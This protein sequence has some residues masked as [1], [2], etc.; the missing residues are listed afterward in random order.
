MATKMDRQEDEKIMNK[1]S[2][3]TNEIETNALFLAIQVETRIRSAINL[4]DMK[5]Y[6]H[7][8]AQLE[9]ARILLDEFLKDY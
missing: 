4:L 1:A 9:M 5:R 6:D 3:P 8:R 7:A 2:E